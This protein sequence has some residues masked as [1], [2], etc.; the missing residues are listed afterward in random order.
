M[1]CKQSYVSTSSDEYACDQEPDVPSETVTDTDKPVT[2]A[3]SVRHS[4]VTDNRR[5]MAAI[6]VEVVAAAK[7]FLEER[8]CD[9]Q[10]RVMTHFKHILEANS[11]HDLIAA[12]MP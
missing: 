2:H 8:L 6:R 12:G 11:S 10:Q 5:N 3:A 9:E 7:N 1:L 4:L